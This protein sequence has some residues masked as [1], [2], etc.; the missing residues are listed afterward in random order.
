MSRAEPSAAGQAG[1][2]VGGPALRLTRL[3]RLLRS[4]LDPR[5]YLHTLRLVHYYNYSYVR[6][7]RRLTVGPDVLIA[8]N[9][10][11]RNGHRIA[12]GARS[13]IGERSSLWAGD[14]GGQIVIGDDALLGPEVFVTASNYSFAAREVP[15]TLQPREELDVAIGS[16]TWLGRGAVVVAGVTVGEGAIVGA[17]A[18]VTHDVAPWAIVAGVPARVIGSRS[19]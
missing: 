16:N 10:S 8:P 9:V 7:Q 18:V 2:H 13:H 4:L 17:G 14:T 1:V 15:V 11:L 3:V 6:E 19:T 5:P 12:I